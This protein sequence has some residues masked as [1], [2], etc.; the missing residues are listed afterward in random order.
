MLNCNLFLWSKLYFQHHYSSLQCHMIFRNHSNML[1]CCSRNI[2]DYYQCWNQLCWLIFLWEGWCILFFRILWWIESHWIQ[3]TEILFFQ[4]VNVTASP[5]LHLH[6]LSVIRVKSIVNVWSCLLLFILYSVSCSLIPF[7]LSGQLDRT[8]KIECATW[9]GK[10]PNFNGLWRINFDQW[11][12]PEI[13]GRAGI[14]TH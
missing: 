13:N 1:N 8:G 4:Y 6:A 3:I 7:V 12:A 2:S 9:S 10:Q 14:N 5:L 11:R